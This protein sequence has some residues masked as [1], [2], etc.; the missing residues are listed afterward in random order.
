MTR[1]GWL[2]VVRGL[3]LVA[4][5]LG[6]AGVLGAAVGVEAKSWAWLG[7][8]IRDLSE[9]EME[10]LA[11]RHGMREGFGVVIVDVVEN[12]PAARAGLKGGDIVVAFDGKPVTDTRTLQRMIAAATMEGDSRLTLLGTAGRRAVRVRLAAMPPE[13]AGER[14]AAEFG[15]VLREPDAQP[16]L[17]GRRPVG[18]ALTPV[19]SVVIKGSAAERSGMEVGDVILQVGDHA[20]I[21][22]EAARTA[23]SEVSLDEPLR[24]TVRRADA[25]VPLTLVGR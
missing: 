2:G 8:R 19:V 12:A 24:L 15:F 11:A 25:L 6:V 16:E 3:T 5:L 17:G 14:T 7:V 4:V 23:L 21:S 9:Q 20:V 1:A 18:G 22:R 10:E 13:V